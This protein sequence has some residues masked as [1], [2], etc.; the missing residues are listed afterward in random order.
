MSA[1]S[2]NYPT[3]IVITGVEQMTLRV[4]RP[5]IGVNS[6][7]REMVYPK[8]NWQWNEPIIRIRAS[9]G[10]LGWGWGRAD[11]AVGQR[12]LNMNPLELLD[13]AAGVLE[14]FRDLEGALW[15]TVGKILGQPVYR[16][17]GGRSDSERLPAYDSTI[18]FN[19]LLCDTKETGLKRIAEDVERSLAGGF[20]ACKMK[21][22][23]GN[24][25]MERRDGLRRDIEVVTLARRTAGQGF[26]IMV[27]ANNAY[28]YD[29]TV[30]FL[31]EVG[32]A[33]IFWVEEMFEEEIEPYRDL[34]R[35]IK[36]HGW[37]TLIADG[38]TRTHEPI[39]FFRPFFQE[40]V[41]DV[42]QHDM[43][44]LGITG[45]RRLAA[46][47]GQFGVGCAPHNWGSLLG[48]YMSLQL[49]KAIPHFIYCEVATLSSHVVDAS[50]YTFK[51]GA[52]SVPDAPGL[53]LDLHQK[54]YDEHYAGQEDWRVER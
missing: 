15:D 4:D 14:E 7:N 24:H 6:Q 35:V 11:V 13:P 43:L 36:A 17:I 51:D 37:E 5:E 32:E 26:D 12:A 31:G 10:T 45:W 18:Y 54:V 46:M 44:G 3:D 38:E 41:L 27:D 48:L 16:L 53:G 42:I 52:F 47:A 19:D 20:R 23:R 39:E 1:P 22:G 21:I 50:G 28:T 25:L 40:G 9:D 30:E 29:E 8:P 49:G 2:A 33:G 34:K